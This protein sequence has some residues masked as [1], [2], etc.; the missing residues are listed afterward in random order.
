MLSLWIWYMVWIWYTMA[1][2]LNLKSLPSD[3]Y[4]KENLSTGKWRIF[5]RDVIL[6][7]A[8]NL[9]EGLNL[10]TFQFRTDCILRMEPVKNDPQNGV[11]WFLRVSKPC[12][13]M[14]APW[15]CTNCTNWQFSGWM[16]LQCLG[17]ENA[18]SQSPFEIKAMVRWYFNG[19]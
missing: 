7:T 14:L 16:S 13:E 19:G 18:S 15:I 17:T 1:S 9:T 8:S 5:G 12:V 10:L 2:V 4:R 3:R 11:T 6:L